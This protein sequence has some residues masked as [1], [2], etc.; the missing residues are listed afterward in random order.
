MTWL[1]L[2]S[3]SP[4]RMFSCRTWRTVT[5]CVISGWSARRPSPSS[6]RRPLRRRSGPGWK[7]SRAARKAWWKAPLC[8][9]PLPSPSPGSQTAPLSGASAALPNSL[10]PRAVTTA[11]GAASW[12]VTRAPN[13]RRWSATSA[14]PRRRGCA[15]YATKRWARRR[16]SLARGGTAAGKAVQRTR[17]K[18]SLM[19]RLK[20]SSLRVRGWTL[21]WFLLKSEFPQQHLLFLL[22]SDCELSTTSGIE[23]LQL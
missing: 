22:S 12:C 2:S 9:T 1:V 20:Q 18:Y 13:T 7:T 19:S 3:L 14:P 6:C 5:S 4:Q 21:G 23:L 8:G 16:R 10:S 11:A 17:M 15:N